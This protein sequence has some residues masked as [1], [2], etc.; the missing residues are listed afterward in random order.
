MCYRDSYVFLSHTKL[1]VTTLLSALH[2]G[3]FNNLLSRMFLKF[4]K[5]YEEDYI[6]EYCLG[7]TADGDFER[8]D[9]R[10]K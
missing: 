4:K 3:F 10:T 6:L 9:I 5:I 2:I 7:F 1:I 8:D